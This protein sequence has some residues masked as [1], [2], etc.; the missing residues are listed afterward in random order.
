MKTVEGDG[1]IFERPKYKPYDLH[2]FHASMLI[3]RRL[4]KIQKLMRHEVIKTTLNSYGHLIEQAET[5]GDTSVGMLPSTRH[6]KLKMIQ[7][8]KLIIAQRQKLTGAQRKKLIEVHAHGHPA[9][10]AGQF[11]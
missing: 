10:E 11:P 4:I 8:N 5:R 9:G 1:E 3:D 2:H 7:H 6:E